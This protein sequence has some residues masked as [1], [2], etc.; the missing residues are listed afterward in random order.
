LVFLNIFFKLKIGDGS[1]VTC[2]FFEK[3]ANSNALLPS[4]KKRLAKR[5]KAKVVVNLSNVDYVYD[6]DPNKHSDAKA[7]CEMSWKDFRKI[8]GNKW[9]PGMNVPFDPI[10]SRLAHQSGISVALLNGKNIK[11][12]NDFLSG[13]EFVGSVIGL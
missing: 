5:F 4:K 3:R 6:K 9:D 1:N 10:A 12:L 7:I 2:L 11:N 13:R 8:V